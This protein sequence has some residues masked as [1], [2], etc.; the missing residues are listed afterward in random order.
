MSPTQ[1]DFSAENDSIRTMWK[2]SLLEFCSVLI[3]ERMIII[4]G[5]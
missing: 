1:K 5:N 3:P 4:H 2:V